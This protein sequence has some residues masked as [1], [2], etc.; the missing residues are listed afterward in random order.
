MNTEL[1][2]RCVYPRTRSI[3]NEKSLVTAFYKCHSF[4]SIKL[5]VKDSKELHNHK[6]TIPILQAINTIELYP[7][8]FLPCQFDRFIFEKNAKQIF[9]MI[10]IDTHQDGRTTLIR[11]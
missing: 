8:D 5:L 7:K 2:I 9:S 10:N 1:L 11:L 6:S 3:I 4:D